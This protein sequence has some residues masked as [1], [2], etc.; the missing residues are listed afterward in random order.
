MDQGRSKDQGNVLN[1]HL[2]VLVL[3]NYIG[4]VSEN[5]VEGRIMV[6]GKLLKKGVELRIGQILT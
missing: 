1:G 5:G 4:K 2:V 6:G 3:S